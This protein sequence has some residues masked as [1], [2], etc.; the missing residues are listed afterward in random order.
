MNSSDQPNQYRRNFL[1]A[2]I[3]GAAGLVALP[4]IVQA[5]Q[6]SSHRKRVAMGTNFMNYPGF[7]DSTGAN[8]PEIRKKI[9]AEIPLGRLGEPAE[10]AYFAAS[11]L[12]G[13]NMCQT[14]SF[15]PVS[16]GLKTDKRPALL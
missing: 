16:G 9:E 8:D 12:D 13:K 10:A 4:K 5:K 6:T 7:I 15:F 11:L 2:G 1:R 3:F 14:G